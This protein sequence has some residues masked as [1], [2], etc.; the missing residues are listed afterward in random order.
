MEYRRSVKDRGE[1]VRD[2]LLL[3]YVDALYLFPN[4][5]LNHKRWIAKIRMETNSNDRRRNNP[6]KKKKTDKKQKPT[7]VEHS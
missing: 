1:G 7:C 4:V 5:T 6:V 3:E 2:D